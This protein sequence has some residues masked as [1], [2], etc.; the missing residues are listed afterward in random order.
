MKKSVTKKGRFLI[1]LNSYLKIRE[2]VMGWN[3]SLLG[4]F[5]THCN[6]IFV[7]LV[8]LFKLDDLISGLLGEQFHR[9]PLIVHSY[10]RLFS[11]VLPLKSVLD[12]PCPILV[13]PDI[14]YEL[15]ARFHINLAG[16][17]N[18][19]QNLGIL[20]RKVFNIFY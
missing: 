18:F 12:R 19:L 10:F 13:H 17:Y 3:D 1:L 8:L 9:D 2:R 7:L 15:V 4:H 20:P 14:A 5:R 11:H 16:F 6:S